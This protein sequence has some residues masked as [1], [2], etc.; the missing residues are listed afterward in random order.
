LK[1]LA[2]VI[3]IDLWKKSSLLSPPSTAAARQAD[4]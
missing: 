1:N 4:D 2:A 3:P